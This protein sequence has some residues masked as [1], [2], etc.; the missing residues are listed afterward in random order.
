MIDLWEDELVEESVLRK[1]DILST[2]MHSV[3]ETRRQNDFPWRVFM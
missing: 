2:L 1:Y 3:I